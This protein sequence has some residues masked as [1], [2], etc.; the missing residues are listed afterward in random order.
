VFPNLDTYGIFLVLLA[1]YGNQS[2]DPETRIWPAA[3][4]LNHD[5]TFLLNLD[6]TFK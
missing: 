6:L 4:K 5:L 3:G 2:L 1:A